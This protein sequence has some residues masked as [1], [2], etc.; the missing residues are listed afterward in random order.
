MLYGQSHHQIPS[1][2]ELKPADCT[3]IP[4]YATGKA[5][6]LATAMACARGVIQVA[7][8]LAGYAEGLAWNQERRKPC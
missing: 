4:Y 6:G 1:G 5:S 8:V 7:V 2:M 3:R